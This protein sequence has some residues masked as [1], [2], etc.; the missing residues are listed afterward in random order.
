MQKDNVQGM[1]LHADW[2]EFTNSD[3]EQRLAVLDV[4]IERKRLLLNDVV[5]ERQLI[6]MRAIRRKRRAEG[7]E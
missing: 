1:E 6:M 5:Q 3:E 4:R 7:K 2:R